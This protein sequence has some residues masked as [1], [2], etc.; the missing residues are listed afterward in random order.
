PKPKPPRRPIPPRWNT[1]S[2]PT[3]SELD[4]Q[5]RADANGALG[6]FVRVQRL[7]QPRRDGRQ[8]VVRPLRECRRAVDRD[9][10][11][12]VAAANRRLPR[13]NLVELLPRRKIEADR[14]VLDE[15]GIAARKA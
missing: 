13:A 11:D 14:P 1:G 9:R 6:C 8:G 10:V 7:S 12:P 4:V 15:D 5:Q 2:T 3:R